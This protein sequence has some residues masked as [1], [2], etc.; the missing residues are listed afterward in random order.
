MNLSEI[1][2]L[3]RGLAGGPNQISSLP[4]GFVFNLRFCIPEL[5]SVMS[6]SLHLF[7]ATT[8]TTEVLIFSCFWDPQACC[9]SR[10]VGVAA[11]SDQNDEDNATLRRQ[12]HDNAVHVSADCPYDRTVFPTTKCETRKAVSI[13]PYWYY[14]PRS[15]SIPELFGQ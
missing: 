8:T 15:T 6:F 13:S 9:H 5:T 1:A 12:F 7:R 11:A 14:G 10:T 4:I 3:N 2:E